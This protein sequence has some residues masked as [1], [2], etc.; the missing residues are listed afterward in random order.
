M[1]I[2]PP[3]TSGT[4][5]DHLLQDLIEEGIN[6]AEIQEALKEV[7]LSEN[8]LLRQIKATLGAHTAD[9]WAS[10]E[11]ERQEVERIE[12]ETET[13]AVAI[14]AENRINYRAFWSKNWKHYMVLAVCAIAALSLSAGNILIDWVRIGLIVF[15]LLLLIFLALLMVRANRRLGNSRRRRHQ[16]L[17]DELAAAR[18]SR[19]AALLDRGILPYIRQVMND[20]KIQKEYYSVRFNVRSAP[21]LQGD[22]AVFRVETE[23]SRGLMEKLDAM[24]RGGSFGIA[25]PRGCGKTSVL[26]AIYKGRLAIKRTPETPRGEPFRVLVTAPVE[27]SS[28]EFLLYLFAEICQTY[29]REFTSLSDS[30]EVAPIKRRLRDAVLRR[31]G[32]L[33][34][35]F[36]VSSAVALFFSVPARTRQQYLHEHVVPRLAKLFGAHWS[37]TKKDAAQV[38][39]FVGK[40]EVRAAVISL[41]LLAASF[42]LFEVRRRR[43]RAQT[44]MEDEHVLR[45]QD[46]GWHAK[47]M[48]QRIRFQQSYSSGWSGTLKLPIVEGGASEAKSMAENQMSL[49]DIVAN[50]KDF[51][52]GITKK[53]R[54]IIAIDELDKVKSDMNAEQ[55]LNDLKGIFNVTDCFYLVSISEE[56]LSNFELRGLPFR[57]AFDSAFD[58]VAHFRYLVYEESRML[59]ERRVIGLSAPYIC[60]CHCTA[61]GLPRDLIRVA[62]ELMLLRRRRVTEGNSADLFVRPGTLAGITSDLVRADLE[63]R[64]AATVIGLRRTSSELAIDEL[65][66]WID[67][68]RTK[69]RFGKTVVA[70]NLLAL[71]A[72]YPAGMNGGVSSS[73]AGE[74]DV[75]AKRLGFVLLGSLYYLATLLELFTD[76]LTEAEVRGVEGNGDGSVEQLALARQAFTTSATLAWPRISSFRETWHLKVVNSPV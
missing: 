19:D 74:A 72:S 70:G 11:P 7:R 34:L 41:V 50:I 36:L 35:L 9:I 45:S 69:V 66:T 47:E 13:R 57:D 17:A 49:P 63:D 28:R 32:L 62:R 18:R 48:L 38:S 8:E 53:H 43:L 59:L 21:G 10:A 39:L 25:G 2:D 56:A 55:F 27:F 76:S 1:S 15:G 44:R 16:E 14:D 40:I 46:L 5:G 6:R 4:S 3:S 52:N 20:P 37:E 30:P 67:D 75:R 42:V 24:P 64:I 54:A 73:Q 12:T 71:C 58:E 22:D 65:V 23:G 26:K 29:I 33:G 61:G 68:V 31:S 51:L 60:L